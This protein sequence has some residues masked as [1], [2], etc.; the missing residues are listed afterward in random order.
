M[1]EM[2]VSR[3]AIGVPGCFGFPTCFKHTS[4]TCLA[5][6]AFATCEVKVAEKMKSMSKKMDLKDF[7]IRHESAS[8]K[9]GIPLVASSNVELDINRP[10][11]RKQPVAIVKR[12]YTK[13]EEVLLES[14]PKKVVAFGKQ[15][16]DSG[17]AVTARETLLGGSNP[18]PYDGKRFLHLAC[19]M[20][21]SDGFTRQ[22]LKALYMTNGMSDGTAA[23]HVSMALALFKTFGI[24]V[25]TGNKI[26]LNKGKL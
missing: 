3:P 9:A 5:C 6:P 20:L 8:I 12:A 23:S 4:D 19:T 16:I 15:L 22:E 1:I 13:A 21:L 7:I 24:A 11:K 18:F 17:L 26:I 14:L 25:E 2:A 10:I